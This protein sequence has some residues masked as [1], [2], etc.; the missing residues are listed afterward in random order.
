MLEGK[1]VRLRAIEPEDLDRNFEWVNDHDVTRHLVIRYPL[2]R[3]VERGFVEGRNA[4]SFA[5]TILAIE[6]KEGVHIGNCGLHE[7]Q[8]ENRKASL[9]IMIGDKQY[10]SNGY[11]TDAVTTLL[12]FGFGEMNLNR[13]WLHVFEFNERAIAC[14]KKCGFVEEGRLRENHYGEGR[15]WD[16][17]TMGILRSEYD[18]LH[19]SRKRS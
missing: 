16:T 15:Y 6:T 11:G 8:P 13:V 19:G 9:G 1:L 17:V 14:Y 4:N 2:S 5:N 3:D 7:V 12:R 10:W 18:A